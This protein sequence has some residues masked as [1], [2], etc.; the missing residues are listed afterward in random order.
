MVWAALRNTDEDPNN[1]TA[2]YMGKLSTLLLWNAQD[3]VDTLEKRRN[4]IIYNNY[5][6]NRKPFIDHPEWVNAIWN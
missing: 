5:Q 2:P 6:H 3:P 1:T 4:D